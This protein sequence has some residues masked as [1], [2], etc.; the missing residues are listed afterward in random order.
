VRRLVVALCHA[1]VDVAFT[2]DISSPS[3]SNA[4]GTL[5]TVWG[6][7]VLAF[8]GLRYLSRRGKMVR[9]HDSKGVTGFVD[10]NGQ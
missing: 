5:I 2:S 1:T 4:V 9:L 7:A 3:V 8:A 6:I 10:Q